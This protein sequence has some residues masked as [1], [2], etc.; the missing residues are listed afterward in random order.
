MADKNISKNKASSVEDSRAA[1]KVK[2]TTAKAADVKKTEVKKPES[3][4][5]VVKKAANAEVKSTEAK[6]NKTEKTAAPVT[7]TKKTEAKKSESTEAAATKVKKSDIKKTEK[8]EAAEAKAQKAELAKAEKKQEKI[9]REVDA[10]TKELRRGLKRLQAREYVGIPDRLLNFFFSILSSVAVVL[11]ALF[12]TQFI[13][14]DIDT[15]ADKFFS[16][17]DGVMDTIGTWGVVAIIFTFSSWLSRSSFKLPKFLKK[18]TVRPGLALSV[19]LLS[20]LPVARNNGTISTVIMMI[21]AFG[22]IFY[23]CFASRSNLYHLFINRSAISLDKNLDGIDGMLGKDTL[24]AAKAG[25]ALKTFEKMTNTIS[26]KSTNAAILSN[27]TITCAAVAITAAWGY[28]AINGILTVEVLSAASVLSL[29]T[30]MEWIEAFKGPSTKS[31]IVDISEDRITKLYNE[32][33]KATENVDIEM[34]DIEAVITEMVN[35][36]AAAKK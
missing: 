13:G 32:L 2:N 15:L 9:Q 25:N 31:D 10:K 16:V 29:T 5:P 6:V 26:D 4:K 12:G 22:L 20:T 36:K 14:L 19:T 8:A 27:V 23:S 35:A 7:K 17:A 3:K 28:C 24:D 30:L 1:S 18:I 21:L 11:F 33:K 34:T